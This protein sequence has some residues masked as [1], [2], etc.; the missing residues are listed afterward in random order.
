MSFK[1]NIT[2]V[3][4]H[5]IR[6]SVFVYFTDTAQQE[7]DTRVLKGKQPYVNVCAQD[8][9]FV[10]KIEKIYII[11]DRKGR[12][13]RK[14]IVYNYTATTFVAKLTSSPITAKSLPL[15]AECIAIFN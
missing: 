10:F 6:V 13:S 11:I 1:T 8:I 5:E 4:N 14:F 15:T 2:F 7:T 3:N 12:V 9:F